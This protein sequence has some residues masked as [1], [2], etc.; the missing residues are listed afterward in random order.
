MELLVE[1]VQT[2]S[3]FDIVRVVENRELSPVGI[4]KIQSVIVTRLS[5]VRVFKPQSEKYY[6]V[7]IP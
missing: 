7:L 1:I 6:S 4:N 5:E 3:V 2:C